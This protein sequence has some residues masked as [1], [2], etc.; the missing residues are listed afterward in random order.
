M[1][2]EG[3]LGR[4]V[5]SLDEPRAAWLV[6]GMAMVAAGALILYAAHGES[7]DIDEFFYYGRMVDDAGRIVQYHSLSLGYL[8]APY[9]GHLQLGGKLIY[10]ALFATVGADYFAFELFNVLALCACVAL[11]FELTRRRVG[12][13][14]ALAPCV[15]LLFLGFAREV[16]LWPFDL[17]TLVS[18]AAGLAAIWALQR[19]DRRGDALACALLVVSVATIE[20]GLAFVVGVAVAVLLRSD[21]WER[22]WVFLVPLVLY[23][24]WWLWARHFD[25]SQLAASNVKQILPVYLDALAAVAGT[26]TGT[27]PIEP[28]SYATVVTELGRGLAILALLGLAV[29]MIH[30]RLPRRFWTWL[31]VL[32]AYWF[33]LTIAARPPEASRYLFVGAVGVLLVG[34]E[35]L[36]G[37]VSGR[38]TAAIAIVA[39]VALPANVAQLLEGRQNDALH[40]DA[41]VSRTE[42]A[43]L[44][45]ARNQVAPSY[46]VSSDP[47]VQEAGGGLFIGL[48]A[49]AYLSG[50]ERNGSLAFS[51]PELRRQP[52]SLRRLADIAL[53][54]AAGIGLRPAEP[55]PGELRNC[56][57]F[58]PGA[59][60]GPARFA[61]PSG[62]TVVRVGGTRLAPVSLRRFASAG[63]GVPIARL[64]PG[65]WAS[66]T[67]PTDAAPDPWSLIVA[68][69]GRACLPG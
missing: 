49:S 68:G 54:G 48:P 56:H 38:L 53:V 44:E 10:E 4:L 13:Q 22:A 30:G 19:G 63:R 9:N 17:H 3:R 66:I 41:P 60:G 31:A 34:A 21:R 47:R 27:N 18:L 23:A 14:T 51:L 52:E 67:I 26:L 65:G 29:R 11:V 58:A 16:L 5:R 45:L 57:R 1:R 25:Q 8:L 59:D 20:L 50:A 32:A 28:G 36:R 42:F 15:L 6:L 2:P 37:R 61:I 62:R 33:F 12:H 46:V 64:R 55:E 40:A 24:A 35:A 39:I 43:M 7:F 69:R